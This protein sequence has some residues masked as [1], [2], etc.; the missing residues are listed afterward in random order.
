[1]SIKERAK[2]RLEELKRMSVID[3]KNIKKV[4]VDNND[5]LVKRIVDKAAER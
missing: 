3:M 2:K 5:G 1:M 4:K